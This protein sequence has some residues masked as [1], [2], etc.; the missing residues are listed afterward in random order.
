MRAVITINPYEIACMH[1]S[2]V[3]E[4]SINGISLT[5]LVIQVYDST[6]YNTVFIISFEVGYYVDGMGRV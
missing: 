1:I 6:S 4:F 3:R 5:S 2:Y